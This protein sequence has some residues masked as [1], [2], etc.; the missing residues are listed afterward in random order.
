MQSLLQD[1]RDLVNQQIK[2]LEECR[3]R[4]DNRIS[5]INKT[6]DAERLRKIFFC[7][8]PERPLVSMD[9]HLRGDADLELHLRS[10]EAKTN[11][12]QL[13]LGK[14]GLPMNLRELK[15][16]RVEH[17]Q[18]LFCLLEPGETAEKPKVKL[19][20]GLWAKWRFIGHHKD[21]PC[22]YRQ[23]LQEL[24]RL[25]Y[26]P[27][28]DKLIIEDLSLILR[29]GAITTIIGENGCGSSVCP[30]L[31]WPFWWVYASP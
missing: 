3:I 24:D 26:A 28:E 10:L 19:P 14:V 18:K 22:Q 29:K 17:Y 11:C 6:V 7:V 16:W 8:V 27:I 12:P 15:S 1:Q 30:E 20:A 9:L 4:L 31:Q 5:Q 21:A 2:E 13:F 23:V 25:G